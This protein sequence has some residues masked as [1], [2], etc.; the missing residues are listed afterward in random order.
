MFHQNLARITGIL[1]ED[2]HA[3]FIISRSFFIISRSFLIIYCSFLIISRSFLLRIGNVSNKSCRENQNTHFT[4]NNVFFENRAVY[5][6]MW[7]NAVESGRPQ[8]KI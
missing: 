1:H 3:F 2:Q 7:K 4:F 6:I 5:E 8:T